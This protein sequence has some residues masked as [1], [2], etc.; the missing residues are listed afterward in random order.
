MQAQ[1]VPMAVANNERSEALAYQAP[2]AFFL[3][4]LPAFAGFFLLSPNPARPWYAM[5]LA[6]L[7]RASLPAI[8][9]CLA[10]ASLHP[11]PQKS[12]AAELIGGGVNLGQDRLTAGKMVHFCQTWRSCT[13]APLCPPLFLRIKMAI[14]KSTVTR[15]VKNAL[16]QK[17]KAK[18]VSESALLAEL[19]AELMNQMDSL[20]MKGYG[21]RYRGEPTRRLEL[22]LTM[23]EARAVRE[24][25]EKAGL[26][27]AQAWVIGLVRGRLLNQPTP[28][29]AALN[30]LSEANRQLVAVGRNLNQIAH[31]LNIEEWRVD[32][33]KGD[34]LGLLVKQLQQQKTAV[35]RLVKDTLI[36]WTTREDDGL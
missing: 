29:E 1:L 2:L 22:R 18:G 21:N 3:K 28:S 32:E 6:S 11:E 12:S 10:V 13:R 7:A 25:A 19:V 24:A 30:A 4:M 16:Q 5:P 31:A 14:I 27:S 15:E 23:P 17:A 26:P 35:R 9:E 34:T 20:D 36:A 33:L 8:D